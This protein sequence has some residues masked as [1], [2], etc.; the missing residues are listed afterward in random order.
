MGER[1]ADGA[2]PSLGDST[3]QVACGAP[4]AGQVLRAALSPATNSTQRKHIRAAHGAGREETSPPQSSPPLL[5]GVIFSLVPWCQ[6]EA[7]ELP[8]A[9]SHVTINLMLRWGEPDVGSLVQGASPSSQSA[10]RTLAA[11]AATP[12]CSLLARDSRARIGFSQPRNSSQNP[13]RSAK[14]R[15]RT[16]CTR[17]A[18]SGF[19][20]LPGIC[21]RFCEK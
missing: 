4:G 21:S 9:Y 1:G 11:T 15:R 7:R 18:G 13:A 12:M 10:H 16:Q 17:E 8:E 19:W 5:F 6:L 14:P 2:C 3:G 20:Q